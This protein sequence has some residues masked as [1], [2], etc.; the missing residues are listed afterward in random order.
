MMNL[1][2]ARTKCGE[3]EYAEHDDEIRQVEYAGVK[4][5]GPNHHEVGNQ[6]MVNETVNKIAYA[7]RPYQRQSQKRTQPQP[8]CADEVHQQER[9][10]DTQANGKRASSGLRERSAK[11][12]KRAGV[13][14]KS[15]LDEAAR[16]RV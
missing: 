16:R 13:F 2:V 11:V 14:R 6:P 4:R 5:T 10:P 15:E 3:H 12:K 8:S 9:Q 1:A 7:T